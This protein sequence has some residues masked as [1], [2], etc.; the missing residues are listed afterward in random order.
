MCT[1]YILHYDTVTVVCVKHVTAA[2]ANLQRELLNSKD[3][4]RLTLQ[5]S[6][7]PMQMS[8]LIVQLPLE[9]LV[10]PTSECVHNHIVQID[11]QYSLLETIASLLSTW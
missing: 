7:Y 2:I 1:Y 10:C 11:V 9:R 8:Q 3:H 4:S 6:A 5:L